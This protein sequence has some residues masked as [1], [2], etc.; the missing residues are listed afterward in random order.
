MAIFPLTPNKEQ[1]TPLRGTIGNWGEKYRF[2]TDFNFSSASDRDTLL[3]FFASN[4]G[5]P[6]IYFSKDKMVGTSSSEN[7][8]AKNTVAAVAVKDGKTCLSLDDSLTVHTVDSL[9]GINTLSDFIPTDGFFY[10]SM[11]YN[12]EG[13]YFKLFNPTDNLYL[14]VSVRDNKLVLTAKSDFV[15]YEEIDIQTF[16][17][18]DTFGESIVFVIGINNDEI[19]FAHNN[20]AKKI[21]SYAEF[22]TGSDMQIETL[23]NTYDLIYSDVILPEGI[24]KLLSRALDDVY[25]SVNNTNY[26]ITVQ[27]GTTTTVFANLGFNVK[28]VNKELLFSFDGVNYKTSLIMQEV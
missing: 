1:K 23:V 24:L 19:V 7:M 2:Q 21:K 9:S 5:K 11:E 22:L 20:Q 27:E 4:S 15:V 12:G 17:L 13:D 6:Y 28:T 26:T 8:R 14:T 16:D 3:D 25:I 10:V 18:G